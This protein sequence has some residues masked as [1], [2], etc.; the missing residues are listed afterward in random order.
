[1]GVLA[2]QNLRAY[3][4]PASA[5][6]GVGRVTTPKSERRISAILQA[7]F[8]RLHPFDGERCGATARLAGVLS[9]RFVTPVSFAACTVTS[10]ATNSKSFFLKGV[11]HHV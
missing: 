4:S 1:M 6:A 2:R 7:L 10:A 9:D 3:S 11:C 5:I 8:L